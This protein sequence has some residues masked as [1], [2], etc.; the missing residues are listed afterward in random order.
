MTNRI[1]M[2]N[3]NDMTCRNAISCLFR[4]VK[5]GLVLMVLAVVSFPPPHTPRTPHAKKAPTT[6]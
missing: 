5:V 4:I 1:T 3:R 6:H 2:T